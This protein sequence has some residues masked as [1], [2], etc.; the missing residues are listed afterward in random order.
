M[1][2]LILL[3]LNR[4]FECVIIVSKRVIVI[5]DQISVLLGSIKVDPQVL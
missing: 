2:D 4:V 1:V 3:N 5:H